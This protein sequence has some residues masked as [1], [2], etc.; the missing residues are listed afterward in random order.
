MPGYCIYLC[1]GHGNPRDLH[2]LTHS[3]PTRRSTDLLYHFPT[4]EQLLLGVLGRYARGVEEDIEAT[5]VR[6][7]ELLR[8]VR[9]WG[10]GMED[11]PEVSVLLIK[12]GAEHMSAD[13]PAPRQ[14]L[15]VEYHPLHDPYISAFAHPAPRRALRHDLDSIPHPAT[16]VHT[17]ISHRPQLT[18]T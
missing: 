18:P 3:F 8:L 13:G 12:L 1:E 11:T 9:E 10:A 5:G 17:L 4:K 6:G 16:P 7:I 15:H 2:V 14:L